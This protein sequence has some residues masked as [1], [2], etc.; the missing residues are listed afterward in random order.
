MPRGVS[1]RGGDLAKRA[2][3]IAASGVALI[4][5]S[6]LFVVAALAVKFDTPGPVFYRG[7]RTGGFGIPF[8]MLKFRSMFRDASTERKGFT[9]GLDDPR[10][11]RV[12]KVLR[13]WKVDELP[14]LVNV[15]RGEMSL[16]GPRP[17]MPYY[18]SKYVGDE[19]SI[20]DVRP[21]ITDYSSIR[22]Y[23][24][25]EVV[26]AGDPDEAFERLVLP[27]KN[28]LRVQYVAERTFWGDLVLIS[29]TV[30]LLARAVLRGRTAQR[31]PIDGPP[32]VDV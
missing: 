10:V 3:D 11:T 21:G 32:A 20:L 25:H 6:P 17:E 31:P 2:F 26:G 5:L 27:T 7:T 19:V 28:R 9:T 1:P 14:Q 15:F 22:F 4:A 8:F 24:L 16:V 30:L 12:G 29:Q 13:R 23:A 18:T